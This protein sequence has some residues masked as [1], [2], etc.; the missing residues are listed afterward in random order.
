MLSRRLISLLT[1]ALALMV[2]VPAF[3]E[4]VVASEDA[5][6]TV[7]DSLTGED[8]AFIPHGGTWAQ[9]LDDVRITPDGKRAVAYCSGTSTSAFGFYAVYDLQNYS[10]LNKI[11]RNSANTAA[12]ALRITDVKLTPDGRY[13][14]GNEDDGLVVIDVATGKDVAFMSHGG[15]WS[16]TLTD[17]VITPDSRRVI[18]YSKGNWSSA[19]GFYDTFDLTNFTR[20]NKLDRNNAST[21]AQALRI[22]KLAVTPDGTMAIALEQDGLTVLDAETGQDIAFLPHGANWSYSL[23]DF[24]ISADSSRVVAYSTGNWSSAFGFY[25]TFDLDN[26]TLL[27]KVDRNNATTAAQALRISDVKLTPD[28]RYA[29]GNEDDGLVVI[30][31]ATGKDVAFMSHG[32]G[33]SYTLTD[34]VITP[35][36]RRVIAYSKGNWSSAFGFYD[37]FDLTNFT[38]INKLDRNNASTAAQALGITKLAVTPDGT[39]AIALERDGLTVLDAETG[40]DIAFLP[41]GAGWSYSLTDF[42]ISADSSRVVAYSKGNWSSAFGFYDTFDLDKM[43]LL[44]KVD[45]TNANTAAQALFIQGLYT[46]PLPGGGAGVDGDGDGV[47]SAQDNCPDVSNPDQADLDGDGIGDA[48][49]DDVDGDS[50]TNDADNCPLTPNA[51]QADNDADGFGDA[52]DPDDD[53]DGVDDVADNCQFDANADQAD[54]DAD[55]MGDVCDPDDDNDGIADGAD[56]CQFDANADQADLD[57]DGLGDV[58]D[59]DIDGDS[60]DNADDCAPYDPAINPGAQ[61]IPYSGVDENCNGM[62]DDT[63]EGVT[64]TIEQLFC[65]TGDRA[66]CNSMS[67]KLRAMTNKVNASRRTGQTGPI[68]GAISQVEHSMLTTVDGCAVGGAPDGND[69]LTDCADQQRAYE[70]LTGLRDW[71]SLLL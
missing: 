34:F 13:A 1:L 9:Q 50:V 51:D 22:T 6:L 37:T 55:G 53:N 35:D 15:G 65:S 4:Q 27:N 24:A 45:R 14:I 47:P 26:M 12:Q 54:N 39:M 5:G 38:R 59:P 23:K 25:D 70:A 62:S 18:A 17:F 7:L 28:G 11:D 16:Y 44:N 67:G 49:D 43:T 63:I 60:W 36:S 66:T 52:C 41:H 46:T 20:I 29:I 21:A 69:R 48:C 40:Q 3:A 2:A 31:V 61:E 19:F 57:A 64:D 10:L 58:C 71:L 68:R 30:D 8:I 56:N 32:G 33:W 42:V